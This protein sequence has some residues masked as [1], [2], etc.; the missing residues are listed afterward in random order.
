M[1][2]AMVEFFAALAFA[3]RKVDDVIGGCDVIGG[4]TT[5]GI[6]TLCADKLSESENDW[7]VSFWFKTFYLG[8]SSYFPA[9]G[10]R[11]RVTLVKAVFEGSVLD[12]SA[13]QPQV[14]TII[15]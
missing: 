5:F 9:T 1:T 12:R 13:D 2:L 7:N 3:R 10:I 8:I 15:Y 6:A 14:K 11:T 4:G